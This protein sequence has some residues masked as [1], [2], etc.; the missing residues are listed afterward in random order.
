MQ[1]G[2]PLVTAQSVVGLPPGVIDVTIWSAAWGCGQEGT[3]P[4]FQFKLSVSISQEIPYQE[5]DHQFYRSLAN[6]QTV[7]FLP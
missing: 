4:G 5:T 3:S 7:F 6:V 2:A 1:F